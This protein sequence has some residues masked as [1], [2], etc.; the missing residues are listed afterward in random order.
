M[1][2]G[3]SAYIPQALQANQ[4]LLPN[5]PQSAS[6]IQAK[7][8]MLQRPGLASEIANG[9]RW[10]SSEV[11]SRG[12]TMSIGCMFPLDAM[13]AEAGDAV[14]VVESVVPVLEAFLDTSAP[15]AMFRVWYGFV[16]GSSGGA[17]AIYSEDRTTYEA[18]T[19]STRLPYEAILGHEV[20][21]TF[22]SNESLNQFLEMYAF[23]VLRNRGT[24]PL[25]WTFTRNWTP[26]LATNQ[27]SAALLDIYQLIGDDTMKLAVRAIRP[28][29][30]GYGQ[31]FS[32]AVIQAFL[33]QV[34]EPLQSQVSVKLARITF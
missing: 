6:F 12:R 13:R 17:G 14:R 23:N 31:P 22:I 20:G 5:N 24:D 15:V 16:V 34:P 32:P 2:D 28:L 7:I 26:G 18:R 21:H 8:T 33:A 29:G 1:L 9:G 11:T 4:A 10:V 30:P 19:P 3:L 27:D 25:Q